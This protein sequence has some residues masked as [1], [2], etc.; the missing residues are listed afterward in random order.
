MGLGGFRVQVSFVVGGRVGGGGGGHPKKK[1]SLVSKLQK[2]R[3]P[4]PSLRLV[5]AQRHLCT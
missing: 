3:P 4:H 5:G 1:D 2:S